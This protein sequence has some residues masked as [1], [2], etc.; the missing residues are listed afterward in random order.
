M[1][2]NAKSPTLLNI[3]QLAER[4]GVHRVTIHNWLRDDRLPIKPVAGSTP[5][6]WLA[7]DVKSFL[8]GG[9]Q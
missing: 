5:P 1:D 7:A 8:N 6:R 9:S 3:S 2:D 4:L